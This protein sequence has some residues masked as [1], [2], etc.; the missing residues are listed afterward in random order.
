MTRS[1]AAGGALVGSPHAQRSLANHLS[2]NSHREWLLEARHCAASEYGDRREAYAREPDRREG[3]RHSRSQC[4]GPGHAA[5]GAG[6]SS[7][8][9][10]PSR[11]WREP[12]Y[13]HRGSHKNL[14]T[15]ATAGFTPESVL[16]RRPTYTSPQ[17]VS[18]MYALL[19]RYVTW[20]HTL[21]N[22]RGPPRLAA[23]LLF[24]HAFLHHPTRALHTRARPAPA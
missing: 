6:G 5:G 15:P 24:K 4:K 2:K 1:A 8:H 18:R 3:E 11:L 7:A 13:I 21:K 16:R 12:S 17:V 20:A 23:V 10:P 19:L 9:P 14:L 22:R